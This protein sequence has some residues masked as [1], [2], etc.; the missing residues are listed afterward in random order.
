MSQHENFDRRTSVEI[1]SDAGSIIINPLAF[2]PQTP[3]GQIRIRFSGTKTASSNT[4]VFNCTIYNL[5][6]EDQDRITE[7]CR[8]VARIDVNA[9]Y[10]LK[11]PGLALSGDIRF[12]AH[13]RQ[14]NNI[15]TDIVC[16]DGFAALVNSRFRHSNK[17]VVKTATVLKKALNILN[18]NN[19][20]T[21]A[22][23]Q[24]VISLITSDLSNKV[25]R[26]L[27]KFDFDGSA[28][29]C[30]NRF[31]KI[32]DTQF[33]IQDG[34]VDVIDYTEEVLTTSP[35]IPLTFKSGLLNKPT[36]LEGGGVAF[37]TQLDVRLKPGAVANVL[38]ENF[39]I[40]T[41]TVS[42]D[43]NAMGPWTTYCEC[44]PIGRT[45]AFDGFGID[46]CDPIGRT[47]R[48]PAFDGFG[49]DVA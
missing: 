8:N 9:G 22:K 19:L 30:L 43:N 26:E 49:I 40:K 3:E 48:T 10:L 29:D 7:I 27:K 34:Q 4:D 2:G 39:L 17:G 5:S 25:P 1:S 35:P 21:S 13:V 36:P 20:A 31:A 42:G 6:E 47:P 12:L 46:E 23:A 44:D 11:G 24:K 15:V 41:T 38:L 16:A 32:A 45:P 28:L 33:V 18:D 37:D 14:G